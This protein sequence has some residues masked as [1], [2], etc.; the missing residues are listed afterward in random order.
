V[1]PS[2]QSEP[3]KRCK[4]VAAK[5]EDIR[6]SRMDGSESVLELDG[7]SVDYL[8]FDPSA[9]SSPSAWQGMLSQYGQRDDRMPACLPC[10]RK[11]GAR[12]GS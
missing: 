10:L 8:L 12:C 6:V 7:S 9:A 5:L 3:R 11:Y 1:V 2:L 4:G